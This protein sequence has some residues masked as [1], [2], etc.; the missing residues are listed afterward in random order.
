MLAIQD[1]LFQETVRYFSSTIVMPY[2]LS[3]QERYRRQWD[4]AQIRFLIPSPSLID[5]PTLQTPCNS[6][7]KTYVDGPGVYYIVPNFRGE[8]QI[9]SL[10]R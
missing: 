2:S 1:T 4:L 7:S 6:T 9:F 10:I 8:H 3:Q 5:E